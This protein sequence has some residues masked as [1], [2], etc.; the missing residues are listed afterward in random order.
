MQPYFF[1]YF[2]YFQL[3]AAVDEIVVYDN[4]EFS[5]GGWINR[6]RILVNGEDSYITLPLKKDSDHLDVRERQLSGT[7]SAL[8]E[9]MLNRISGAY[10][11][12]PHFA[13]AFPI[14]EQCIRFGNTNLFRFI[15]NSIDTVRSYLKI[16]TPLVTSST[17]AIDHSLKSESKVVAICKARKADAYINPGGGKTLYSRER[18]RNDG[19]DLI[20]LTMGDVTY[21][22]FNHPFVPALSIID[23]M[24]FKS[25]DE[26]RQFLG[27]Y[28]L[29]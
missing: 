6:N 16:G 26:I 4:I 15:F 21:S 28:I 24:M 2:G 19:I 5:K 17:I 14:I 1:P 27:I 11:S 13:S 25:V 9:K 18:F 3:M 29:E 7:W 10:R 8:R 12:A 23:L 20:F 22:Q